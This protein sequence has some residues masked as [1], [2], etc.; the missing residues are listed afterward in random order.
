MKESVARGEHNAAVH[1]QQGAR[2]NGS[3]CVALVTEFTSRGGIM[4]SAHLPILPFAEQTMA[5]PAI[6]RRWTTA[7]VRALT[8]EDRAWPRY[9]LID[10]ELLVTPAPRSIHQF[11]CMGLLLLLSTY[12]DTEPVGVAVMSPSDLE[13]LP[14][15][16]T[17]PDLFVIPADTTMAGDGLEWP[18]VK[19]LLLAVEVLS[20]SSLRTDRVRKR[21]FYLE[22]GVE[23]YW[24]IDAEARV[25]ERWRPAQETP[26]VLRDRI[27]WAPRQRQPL[28]I[29]VPDYFARIDEKRRMFV[30]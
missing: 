22:N 25:F 11:A 5:M 24:I 20:P 6:K 3:R 2:A 16:L 27:E 10:G 17:Q 15:T 26:D 14:G 4:S 8:S 1:S 7:D 18:D 9:E 21:D 28:V 12:L 13:L 23:E 19:S 29:D 30:R